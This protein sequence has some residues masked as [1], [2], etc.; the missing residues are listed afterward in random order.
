MVNDSPIY[1]KKSSSRHEQPGAGG[2]RSEEFVASDV[3]ISSPWK[4]NARRVLDDR[5]SPAPRQHKS[6]L[7]LAL[8]KPR[9]QDRFTLLFTT[10]HS[11]LFFFGLACF[12]LSYSRC[13]A[14]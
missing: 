4:D 7:R 1:D 8:N 11:V 12:I 2:E 9:S 14:A 13:R 10:D 3:H 6:I 5:Y